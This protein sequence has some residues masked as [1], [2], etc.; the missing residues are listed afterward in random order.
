MECGKLH[1]AFFVVK[2]TI[3]YV[4]LTPGK[5]IKETEAA[6]QRANSITT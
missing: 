3:F 2:E 5:V 1:V 4:M 6:S